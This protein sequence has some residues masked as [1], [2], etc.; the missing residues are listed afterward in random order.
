MVSKMTLTTSQNKEIEVD[1][2]VII[3]NV[4]LIIFDIAPQIKFII[5]FHSS[6][7]IF[8]KLT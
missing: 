6:F 7:N 2:W 4:Q 3:L 5:T 8:V 1:S